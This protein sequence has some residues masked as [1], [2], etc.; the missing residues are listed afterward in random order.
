[1]TIGSDE[2][3]IIRKNDCHEHLPD[4]DI[5]VEKWRFRTRLENRVIAET[6][7]PMSQIYN[8]EIKKIA[9]LYGNEVMETF[10]KYTFLSTTLNRRR[11]RSGIGGGENRSII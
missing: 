4:D 5:E 6:T 7:K 2:Y 11:R 1:M 3:S 8:E 10:P 9:D